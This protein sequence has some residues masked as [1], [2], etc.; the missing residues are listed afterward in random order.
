MNDLISICIPTYNGEKY[1]KECLDTVLSQSYENIEII[2]VDDCSTDKTISIIEEYIQK[3]NRIKLIKNQL[4]IGLVANWNKCLELANGEWIKFVFQDDLIEPNCLSLLHDAVGGHS[5]V[6]CDRDFIFDNSVSE[7]TK[8]YYTKDLLS[9]KKL[10][11]KVET[12]I[13]NNQQ[14]SEIAS[15]HLALNIIGEPTAVMFRKSVITDLGVFNTDFSQI[16]DLEYWL[17]IAT[18]K[19]LVYVPKRLVS[20]R[21]HVN[22]TSA[23]NV[24][25]TVKFKPRYID[26]LLLAQE[27]LFG[28]Y[29]KSYREITQGQYSFKLK[30]YIRSKMFEAK[31]AFEKDLSVSRDY[32]DS[33]L[34]KY[35]YLKQFY[36]TS[37]ITKVVYNLV[38][39]KRKLS[40]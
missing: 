37:F 15:N 24:I 13:L 33:L 1:L 25:S 38:L 2:I 16:C 32:F 36:K 3:D 4:N 20:F 40:K 26:S 11:N 17:R 10:F 18:A 5:I 14:V 6:V 28:A 23:S 34:L 7:T 8:V 22:S 35:P 12:T 30:M 21:V 39:I 19:G 29:Y 9:L 27:M 31:A